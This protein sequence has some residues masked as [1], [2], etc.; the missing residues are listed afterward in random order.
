M[1]KKI[2][3]FDSPKPIKMT[4]EQLSQE[5]HKSKGGRAGGKNMDTPIKQYHLKI[6]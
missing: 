6:L 3:G 4:D 2:S 1:K 5:L